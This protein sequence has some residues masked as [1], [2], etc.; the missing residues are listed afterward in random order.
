MPRAR[1]PAWEAEI[2]ALK[3]KNARVW[4]RKTWQWA[5]DNPK[6][7]LH[8]KFIWDV[9]RAAQEY[10]DA[11]AGELIRA[12]KFQVQHEERPLPTLTPRL[13]ADVVSAS[14]SYIDIEIGAKNAAFKKASMQAELDRIRSGIRRAMAMALYYKTVPKFR[15]DLERIVTDETT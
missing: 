4:R 3:D 2:L 11:R 9:G 14:G 6:S 12:L 13:V 8:R 10:W 5:R 7:A 15:R 1:P